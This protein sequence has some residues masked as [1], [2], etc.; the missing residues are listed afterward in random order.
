MACDSSGLSRAEK[1]MHKVDLI[2]MIAKNA[3][4]WFLFN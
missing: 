3:V 2:Y 1:F 4:S